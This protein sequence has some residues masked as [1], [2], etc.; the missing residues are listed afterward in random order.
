[1]WVIGSTLQCVLRGRVGRT[2]LSAAFDS[3]FVVARRKQIVIPERSSRFAKR[4]R[5]VVE[6]PL[7]VRYRK[8]QGVPP[9]PRVPPI[10]SREGEMHVRVNCH[11]SAPSP[12]PRDPRAAI[13]RFFRHKRPAHPSQTSTRPSATI[14]IDP[15][16]ARVCPSTRA[17]LEA[18]QS[19]ESALFENTNL[20]NRAGVSPQPIPER[21][22]KAAK[23]LVLKDFTSKSFKLKDLAR[24]SS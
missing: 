17:A 19:H 14:Q 18:P 13:C 9:R 8:H 6:G 4:S 11:L 15:W 3:D 24:F 1:M 10:S 22:E 20:G 21:R 16:Q 5:Y 23:S 12:Q 7:P 2:L